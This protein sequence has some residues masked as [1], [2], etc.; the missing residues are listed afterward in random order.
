MGLSLLERGA[1]RMGKVALAEGVLGRGLVR[2]SGA[3]NYDIMSTITLMPSARLAPPRA[4]HLVRRCTMSSIPQPS[5]E[6]KRERNRI[7]AANRRARY[8]EKVR[9][10]NRKLWAKNY[11]KDRERILEQK[12]EWSAK[13]PEKRRGYWLKNQYGITLEQYQAMFE[14]QGGLCAACH[15]PQE[16]NELLYVDHDHKTGKVR[17]LIHINCNSAI[18]LAGDDPIR[19]RLLADYLEWRNG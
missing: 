7:K 16:E 6:E 17:G 8:P 5:P 15:E 1:H 19:L 18:G 14:E 9:E 4:V 10:Y 13:N 3:P 12:R 11:E 2:G